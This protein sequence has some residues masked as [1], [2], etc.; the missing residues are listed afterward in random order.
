MAAEVIRLEEGGPR[1][2]EVKFACMENKSK[3]MVKTKAIVRIL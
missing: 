3:N 2:R 1:A